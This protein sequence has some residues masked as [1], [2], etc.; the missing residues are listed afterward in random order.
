M[1]LALSAL[2][3]LNVYAGDATDAY[4]HSPPPATPT[5]VAIDDAYAEWYETRFNKKID[6]SYVLPVLHALQGHPE[7]G[8]LWEEHI[9]SILTSPDLGFCAKLQNA[10]MTS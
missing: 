1:F 7:S 9:T 4:A 10:L 2:L 3:G 6:R 5:S 8:R